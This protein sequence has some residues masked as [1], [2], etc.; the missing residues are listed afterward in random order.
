M[1]FD[2]VRSFV[3]KGIHFLPPYYR[4]RHLVQPKETDVITKI[5]YL[6]SNLIL[7][8]MEEA[9]QCRLMSRTPVQCRFLADT[10]RLIARAQITSL[11]C[12]GFESPFIRIK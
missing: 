3:M 6:I 7:G 5:C 8:T 12:R 2:A 9:C 11:K 1:G 10:L 4:A